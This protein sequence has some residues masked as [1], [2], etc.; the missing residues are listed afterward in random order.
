MLGHDDSEVATAI[1]ELHRDVVA[2][3][4]LGAAASAFYSQN[5]RLEL[6]GA[7]VVAL[8][9]DTAPDCPTGQVHGITP[10]R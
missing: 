3:S 1:D 8:M 6:A 10:G 7:K 2:R 5:M 9:R 4:R